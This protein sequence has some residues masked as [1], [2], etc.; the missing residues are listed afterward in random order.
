MGEVYQ[1]VDARLGR[2]V[3]IK[4]LPVDST[5]TEERLKRLEHEARVLAS[6]NHPSI[7]SICGLEEFE[8][9]KFLVMELVP[10]E[11]LAER[12]KRGP[13][14]VDDA[15]G[16]GRLVAEA[17]EVA[18]EKGII[19]R[20]LKPA[21]I[22]ITPDG[23]LKLL[24]FG[25]ARIFEPV[26]D[27]SGENPTLPSTMSMGNLILGTAAYMSPEQARGKT[28]DKRTDIWAFGCVLFEML[29]GHQ[30]FA[31]ETV[32]D[33]IT[34][35]LS[36]VPDMEALPK[37]IPAKIR[38][39]IRKCTEKDLRLRLHDIADARIE[40]DEAGMAVGV[41]IGP[42]DTPPPPTPV[43]TVPKRRTAV[44]VLAALIFAFLLFLAGSWFRLPN[45]AS[46]T[47]TGSLLVG[48]ST[49]AWGPRVSPDGRTVSFI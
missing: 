1:A 16:I 6:L 46:T 28:V 37:E 36:S 5:Q 12:I 21:N 10:G 43:P 3:A 22:M 35:I 23:K 27:V 48:G 39:L 26:P 42:M 20:D 32:S 29:T 45:M 24:D 25:L 9:R 13:V 41:A 47:W 17:L 34:A 19:H 11:T 49:I 14:R 15:I 38:N 40:I 30:A 8:G 31:G 18:H 7:A 44:Y 33:I 4:L 2:N